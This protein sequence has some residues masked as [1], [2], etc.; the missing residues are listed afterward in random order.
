MLN[1]TCPRVPI[2]ELTSLEHE[3]NKQKDHPTNKARLANRLKRLLILLVSNDQ[4]LLNIR[5]Y[6]IGNSFHTLD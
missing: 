2:L 1:V 4:N 6:L 5:P 3:H